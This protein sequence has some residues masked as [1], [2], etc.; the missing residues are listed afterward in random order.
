MWKNLFRNRFQKGVD[1]NWVQNW[2]EIW[3]LIQKWA[4][5]R[6]RSSKILDLRTRAVQTMAPK[7]HTWLKSAQAADTMW[8]RPSAA[9]VQ[10]K[11]PER[12]NDD[13]KLTTGS[14]EN[15]HSEKRQPF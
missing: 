11:G 5:I 2:H 12:A 7:R 9:R 10:V 14:G 3:E 1:L 4:Q 6:K 15:R 13:A 8:I